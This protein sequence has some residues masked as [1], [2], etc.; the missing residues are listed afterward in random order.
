MDLL[1]LEQT[2]AL[3]AQQMIDFFV[4]M[5]D[6]KLGFQ[7]DLESAQASAGLKPAPLTS[8]LSPRA[9][10]GERIVPSLPSP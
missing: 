6:L 9:G 4:Q 3:A 8:V 2:V 5:P 7:I 1:N 10:R